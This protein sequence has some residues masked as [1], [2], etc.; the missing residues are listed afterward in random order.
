M[1]NINIFKYLGK[2]CRLAHVQK[3]LCLNYILGFCPEGPLCNYFHLKSL[4]HPGQD[5]LNYLIKNK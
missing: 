4:I 1:V 3:E 2:N 5:N